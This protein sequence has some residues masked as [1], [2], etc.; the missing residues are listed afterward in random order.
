LSKKSK[1]ASQ[2]EE[3]KPSAWLPMRTGLILMGIL[4][5]ALVAW[6]TLQADPALPLGERILWGLG[7]A[8]SL[9]IVF[10]VIFI[11]NRYVLK[12]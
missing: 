4:S 2:T 1:K 3:N 7:F 12:R 10:A 11:I 6:V 5:A 9:W 8:V